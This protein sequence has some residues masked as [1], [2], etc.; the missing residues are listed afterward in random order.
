MEAYKDYLLGSPELV[1]Y[2]FQWNQQ[3]T[4]TTFS[5]SMKQRPTRTTPPQFTFLVHHEAKVYKD[6]ISVHLNQRVCSEIQLEA[7]Q[8]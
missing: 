5:A 3:S 4:K 8:F 7:D 2:G 6:Y 1:I